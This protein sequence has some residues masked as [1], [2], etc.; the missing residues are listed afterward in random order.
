MSEE[1]E[2]DQT[3][4]LISWTELMTR[5]AA[6]S[7]KFYG[8]LLDWTSEAMEMGGFTYT[9]FKT[10]EKSVAGMVSLPPDAESMPVQWMNYITVENLEASRDKAVQLGA[11]VCKDVT[12]LKMGRFVILR[13][14][15]GAVV[16]LWQFA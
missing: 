12:D 11:T 14:P 16:G 2:M 15:Q 10:G 6:G 7:A 13:D 9:I 5:D 3:P 8:E 4:G 1:T